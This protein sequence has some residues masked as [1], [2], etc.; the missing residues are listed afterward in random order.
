MSAQFSKLLKNHKL[1]ID[2]TKTFF[3]LG[4]ITLAV[5]YIF[6]LILKPNS[7]RSR[8]SSRNQNTSTN[9]G[10]ETFQDAY[11]A[12]TNGT[13]LHTRSAPAPIP[14]I[15]SGSS[16]RNNR[17][18]QNWENLIDADMERRR[19]VARR[20]IEGLRREIQN[21]VKKRAVKRT[22]QGGMTESERNIL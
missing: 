7:T 12:F 3:V 4:A 8:S 15:T 9:L 10:Q 17:A 13:G 20:N 1:S 19:K 2:D 16:T 22:L 18:R 11:S 14:A 6:S 5:G 21:E